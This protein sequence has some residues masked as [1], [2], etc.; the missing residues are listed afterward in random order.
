MSQRINPYTPL[1]LRLHKCFL[2][3][4]PRMPWALTTE[5]GEIVCRG[6]VNWESTERIVFLINQTRAMKRIV[7]ESPCTSQCCNTPINL[8]RERTVRPTYNLT[9]ANTSNVNTTNN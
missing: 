1:P 5:F 3:D 6:C 4:L 9:E 7:R 2:C 8:S